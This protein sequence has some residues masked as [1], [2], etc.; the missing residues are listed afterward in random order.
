VDPVILRNALG[1]I[2]PIAVASALAMAGE[3]VT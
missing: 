1:R 3:M 2:G